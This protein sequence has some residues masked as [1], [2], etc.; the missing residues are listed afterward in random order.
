MPRLHPGRRAGNGVPGPRGHRRAGGEESA[1]PGSGGGGD[2]VSSDHA[3]GWDRGGAAVRGGSALALLPRCRPLSLSFSRLSPPPFSLPLA[4][5]SGS[6]GWSGETAGARGGGG[7]PGGARSARQGRGL[8][9]PR[10]REG[11]RGGEGRGGDSA[12]PTHPCGPKLRP[13]GE[14]ARERW[15]RRGGPQSPGLPGFPRAPPS[16]PGPASPPFLPPSLPA[17]I[18]RRGS[19][20]QDPYPPATLPL[21]G[22]ERTT[23]GIPRNGTRAPGI[24]LGPQ[25]WDSDSEGECSPASA[26][27]LHPL[28]SSSNLP[29]HPLLLTGA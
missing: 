11:R 10:G 23:L 6:L 15:A 21:A 8:G 28:A 22:Q 4:G 3:S 14:P 20:Y 19:P 5:S 1:G 13:G 16:G 2:R 9:R 12:G 7:G 17:A 24:G 26:A 29:T 18:L 27:G 25:E